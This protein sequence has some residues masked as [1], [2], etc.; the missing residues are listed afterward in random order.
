MR[1]RRESLK[2]F[3]RVV[4]GGAGFIISLLIGSELVRNAHT[5]RELS[6]PQEKN[7]ASGV[8]TSGQGTQALVPKYVEAS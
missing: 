1:Q 5:A 4:G 3:R 8:A 7:G 2:P 6:F